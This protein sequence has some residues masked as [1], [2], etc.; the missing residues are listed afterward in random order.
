L[1]GL[2]VLA[3]PFLA[4]CGPLGD[5]DDP[6]TATAETIAQPT[7]EIGNE[8]GTGTGASTPESFAPG[9]GAGDVT[10]EA[11]ETFVS[12]GSASTP[13]A[14]NPESQGTPATDTVEPVN[15]P[16][17]ASGTPGSA[18]PG[19]ATEP[20]STLPSYSGSDGTSGATPE[21]TST[22][23]AS[24]EEAG[25]S[26]TPGATPNQPFFVREETTPDPA[27]TAVD[28]DLTTLVP[29][30]VE[31]CDP[32]DVVPLAGGQNAYFT[33]SEVNFRE[34][35]GADCDT[36]SDTP[37]AEGVD[38]VVLSAPVTRVGEEELVWI[39]IEADGERGWVV[40]E[41]LAPAE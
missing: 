11:T 6:A 23:P 3:V 33:L 34:G 10:P 40:I 13:V 37:L 20:V 29:Y 19:S 5:E 18:A 35:P 1:L 31:S 2:A 17:T 36:I 8:D 22:E 27:A 30:E 32:T 16:T 24:D 26:A 14:F 39:Q 7:E 12:T 28:G 4:G 21:L 15:P 9:T 25:T 41:A 38:V